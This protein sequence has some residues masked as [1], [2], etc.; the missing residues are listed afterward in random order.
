MLQAGSAPRYTARYV[1]W[2]ST[3][4]ISGTRGDRFFLIQNEKTDFP[5]ACPEPVEGPRSG[6]TRG[7]ATWQDK[8]LVW[9]KWRP[10]SVR[11]VHAASCAG[12]LHHER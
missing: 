11:A 4:G 8:K 7:C 10:Y 5:S 3:A 6:V 2:Y 9:R 1:P 12:D